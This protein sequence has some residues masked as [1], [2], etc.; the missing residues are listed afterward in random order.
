MIG[1][2]PHQIWIGTSGSLRM[3][4]KRT[5]WIK[6]RI[7]IAKGNRSEQLKSILDMTVGLM[8]AEVKISSI[9]CY[10]LNLFKCLLFMNRCCYSDA[11]DH[12][13]ARWCVILKEAEITTD[14]M[15]C[16][17]RL[18]P[19]L[20][21][22][23]ILLFASLVMS[24]SSTEGDAIERSTVSLIKESMGEASSSEESRIEAKKRLV[25]KLLKI[26]L[27]TA[28]Q[29]SPPVQFPIEYHDR[30]NYLSQIS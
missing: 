9:D 5:V 19:S 23:F 6:R 25:A 27:G 12:K 17:C 15:I 21:T 13:R 24:D 22:V 10:L 18:S 8:F 1:I 2:P 4:M 14:F 28:T 16:N 20:I 7:W 11:W 29:N 30:L 3:L 26:T